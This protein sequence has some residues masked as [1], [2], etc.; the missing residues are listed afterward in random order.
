MFIIITSIQIV[1]NKN[2]YVK[3]TVEQNKNS[4]LTTIRMAVEQSLHYCLSESKMPYVTRMA[5]LLVIMCGLFN[6]HPYI[7][8]FVWDFFFGMLGIMIWWPVDI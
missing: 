6:C 3:M 7:A 4:K 2:S 8:I 1:P 5:I